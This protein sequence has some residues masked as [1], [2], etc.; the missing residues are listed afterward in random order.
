MKIVIFDISK[1]QFDVHTDVSTASSQ[2]ECSS[3]TLKTRI[4][5]GV[6]Y[7]GSCFVGYGEFH[8]TKRGKR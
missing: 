2:L 1:G 5:A 6:F 8:R 7:T 3:R 4:S